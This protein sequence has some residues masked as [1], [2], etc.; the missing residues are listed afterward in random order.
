[1]ILVTAKEMRTADRQTIEEIG[2]PGAVLMENAAQGLAREVAAH[3]GD[4]EGLDVAA[5]CGKGNNG[6]D[7]LAAL[8]ILKNQGAEATAYLFA[9]KD[10]LTGDAALNLKAALA[11]GVTVR[12]IPD[13]GTMDDFLAEMEAHVLYLDA[14][15]GT[16]LSAEV[17]GLTARAI[18]FL[19]QREVPVVAVDIPSG[20]AAETG[21]PL[22]VAVK[23][24]LTVTFGLIKLGLA[25]DPLDLAGEV[26]VVDISIP[27]RVAAGLKAAANDYARV[28]SLYEVGNATASDLDSAR[29]NHES[30]QAQ[31]EAVARDLEL[32]KKQLDYTV[33]TAPLAGAIAQVPVEVHQTVAAGAVIATLSTDQRLEVE[34][35]VPETFVGLLK[36]DE[37]AEVAFDAW[38]GFKFPARV[39]EVGVQ[40]GASTTYPVK[41]ALS[42]ADSR[43]RP[44][45]VGEVTFSLASPSARTYPAAPPE[46]VFG[47]PDGRRLAWVY[48]PADQTVHARELAIG[49][50]TSRGLEIK[51]G[52]K[53]GELVV[54]RGIHHL[55]EG[56]KARPFEARPR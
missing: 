46:A 14:L 37:P 7:G 29:A 17:T 23:A 10:D 15:L 26:S 13:D 3:Y 38:P 5:F 36:R 21:M 11:C 32:A 47:A 24:E 33:L 39:T 30:R 25:L 40:V 43:V 6:G 56:Q 20:L 34:T 4:P 55:A 19:N 51:S 53:P 28:R 45:M 50:L 35:G 22:G 2:L 18:E 41:L 16:G 49:E 27:P 52:L 1:M 31:H 48:D 8:R 9:M 42:S 44:G 54:T 12:E